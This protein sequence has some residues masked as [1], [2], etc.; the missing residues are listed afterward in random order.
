MFDEMSKSKEVMWMMEEASSPDLPQFLFKSVLN[1][2]NFVT[3]SYVNVF[4][5][6][7]FL[8]AMSVCVC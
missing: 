5:I 6:H 4:K 1:F 8:S 7:R 3:Q 2:L